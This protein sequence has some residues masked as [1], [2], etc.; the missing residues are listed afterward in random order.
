[1]TSHRAKRTGGVLLGS[2]LMAANVHAQDVLILNPDAG[3]SPVGSAQNL[4]YGAGSIRIT[5]GPNKVLISEPL[6]A[7]PR[8]TVVISAPTGTQLGLGCYE[9]GQRFETAFRP[10]IDMDF[11]S[12]GCNATFG[13]FRILDLTRDISGNVIGI[14]V[15]FAQQCESFG[16]AV[17]GKVRFNSKVPTSGPFMEP[18]LTSVGNLSFTAQ[19]GAIGSGA[20]GG[21]GDI[22][23]TRETTRPSVNFE[24]GTRF[25]Y[26]GVLPGGSSGNWSLN[27]AAP[28]NVNLVVGAYPNAT[29]YPFHEITEPGL[30]FSYN[31]GCNSLVGSFDVTDIR[32]DG[33]DAVPLRLAATFNQRCPNAEGPLTTGA[34]NY[35]AV[36]NGPTNLYGE[37]VLFKSRF[38]DGDRPS[39][40]FP[41]CE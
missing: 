25:Q 28:G 2:L 6:G 1:M 18:V 10:G 5:N 16:K 15:D 26:S 9:R 30:S 37:G 38:E 23:L 19:I 39:L 4:S 8:W 3:A 31:S 14:A 40:Y 33:L 21:M 29:R 13:R 32:Y 24:N 34:I 7:S 11:D 17:M 41:S 20:P 12:R 36:V 22:A 35:T 27:M